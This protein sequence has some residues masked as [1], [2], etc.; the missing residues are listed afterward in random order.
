MKKILS[1]LALGAVLT[2][3]G[4]ADFLRLEMGGGVWQQT[5]SGSATRTDGDGV[6]DLDGTYT[7]AEKKSSEAYA[8][9]LIKHPIPIIPNL[10]V[11]YVSISDEGTTEGKVGGMQILGSAPT[12]M[13][14]K[15]YDV[16]PYYNLLDNTFWITL[17]LGVDV[18]V[19]QSD[20]VVSAVTGFKGYS[21]KD[22]TVIPLLYVRARTELPTTNIGLEA[23]VKAITDGTNTMYDARAKIDYT[24]DFAVLQ[25]GIEV[26]YRMQKIK[27]DDGEKSQVNLDYSGVYAGLMLRF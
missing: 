6:L 14:V 11:E 23:D 8:W 3:A 7:S 20:V 24:F 1:T 18:K 9:L 25:P 5:P 22:T 26:G 27:S 19:V 21:S 13:D 10:R 2:T 12:T 16:I 15:E 4:S 17:D